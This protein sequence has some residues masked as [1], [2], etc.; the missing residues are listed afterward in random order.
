MHRKL[1]ATLATGLFGLCAAFVI[2]YF[3]GP[4]L[5][6]RFDSLAE[7]RP[8]AQDIT[9]S[10]EIEAAAPEYFDSPHVP[11][12]IEIATV[13]RRKQ[14]VRTTLIDIHYHSPI[15]VN[16]TADIEASLRQNER[17]RR[18]VDPLHAGQPDYPAVIS[19]SDP[20]FDVLEVTQLEWPVVLRLDGLGL[21]WADNAIP[22]KVGT[23]LAVT[24]HWT[25]R[26]KT[27]GEFV[28]RFRLQDINNAAASN[29]FPSV[30]DTVTMTI[31]D[32][33]RIAA[34]SD[35]VTLPLSIWTHGMPARWF[36]RMTYF[37]AAFSAFAA[38]LVGIFGDGWGT[39]FLNWIGKRRRSP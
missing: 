27:A 12:G 37:G 23:P 28:L 6:S 13:A 5:A 39:K 24:E 11:P 3:A 22:I 19:D 26:A 32:V 17:I 33:E 20:S 21:D 4:F 2:L 38:L 10:I 35:D 25:P 34:G 30:S 16:D 31:N 14:R 15:D 29:G 18:V 36:D 9:A 7:P 8:P 1:W